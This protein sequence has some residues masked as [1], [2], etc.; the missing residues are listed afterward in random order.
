MG[1]VTILPIL[2]LPQIQGKYPHSVDRP[3]LSFNDPEG[4]SGMKGWRKGKKG[5]ENEENKRVKEKKAGTIQE[6]QDLWVKKMGF[7]VKQKQIQ[8]SAQT[9]AAS[10]ALYLPETVSLSVN[11]VNIHLAGSVWVLESMYVD[12]QPRSW[13]LASWSLLSYSTATSSPSRFHCKGAHRVGSLYQP[14]VQLLTRTRACSGSLLSGQWLQLFPPQITD[15]HMLPLRLSLRLELSCPCAQKSTRWDSPHPFKDQ[16]PLVIPSDQ[17]QTWAPKK[18]AALAP[19]HDT[20]A[21]WDS[22]GSQPRAGLLSPAPG[23]VP[24]PNIS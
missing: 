8:T 10:W 1:W 23:V 15:L 16:C 5:R 18:W 3:Q 20:T 4:S 9:K 7:G 17:L 2:V 12:S 11:R 24:V 6:R 19:A 14:P 13:H 21:G 22:R